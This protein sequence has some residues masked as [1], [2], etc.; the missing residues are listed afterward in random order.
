MKK[1]LIG[2]LLLTIVQAGLAQ[3]S[4][5]EGVPSKYLDETITGHWTFYWLDID[6]VHIDSADV[7]E[8]TVDT[9]TVTVLLTNNGETVLGNAAGDTVDI[10]GLVNIR[11]NARVFNAAPYLVIFDSTFETGASVDSAG[12]TFDGDGTPSVI[13]YETDGHSWS[14]T[15]NTSDQALFKNASGGYVFDYLVDAPKIMADTTV[16][17]TMDVNDVNADTVTADSIHARTIAIDSSLTI[18]SGGILSLAQGD[19]AYLANDAWILCR[20]GGDTV[21]YGVNNAEIMEMRGNSV[22]F[23]K[24]AVFDS[25]YSL[26]IST[27]PTTDTTAH[28]LVPKGNVRNLPIRIGNNGF[29]D[30]GNLV[31]VYNGT[32]KITFGTSGITSGTNAG[33]QLLVATTATPS[34]TVPVFTRAGDTNTGFSPSPGDGNADSCYVIAGGVAVANFY[35][36]TGQG[37]TGNVKAQFN[38]DVGITGHLNGSSSICGSDAFSG[39]ATADTITIGASLGA[40]LTNDIIIPA[41]TGAVG[42]SVKVLFVNILSDTTFSVNRQADGD[43]GQTWSWQRIALP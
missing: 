28:L 10:V 31:F 17:D 27:S 35:E 15:L 3:W 18:G 6:T 19:T 23:H 11:N 41:L 24:S 43:A 5:L 16:T 37:W 13:F 4:A 1:L 25:S 14:I 21:V 7:D 42:D 30:D 33:T 38:G 29:F 9:V 26:T 8:I 22:R 2:I 32:P 20:A 34:T 40:G 36:A 39:T 12:I